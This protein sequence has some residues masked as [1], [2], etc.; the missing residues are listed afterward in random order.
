MLKNKSR[1]NF[2][3]TKLND[4]EFDD[5][6]RTAERMGVSRS[7]AV[8]WFIKVGCESSLLR[9]A[10]LASGYDGDQYEEMMREMF[11]DRMVE[12]VGDR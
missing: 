5:L 10:Y 12:L 9:A 2:V 8:R 1:V 3:G 6:D 7:E 11:H 4:E